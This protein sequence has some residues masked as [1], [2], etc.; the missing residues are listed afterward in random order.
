MASKI[1]PSRHHFYLFTG[2]FA[3]LR[4]RIDGLAKAA[5]SGSTG[6]LR[7]NGADAARTAQGP[8]RPAAAKTR[9]ARNG[10]NKTGIF[11]PAAKS[12]PLRS[13]K[14]PCFFFLKI[15][16][17]SG[18]LNLLLKLEERPARPMQLVSAGHWR[19]DC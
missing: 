8:P 19:Q 1:R 2:R 6:G 10:A 18:T 11:D 5:L 16:R 15:L 7:A 14:K 17:R 3:R 12:I 4:P 13:T 9:C